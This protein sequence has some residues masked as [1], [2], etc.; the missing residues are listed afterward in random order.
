MAMIGTTEAA[1]RL[2]VSPRRDAA[3]ISQGILK[4]AK[5][6]KTW[7]VDEAEV[8]RVAKLKRP[9]GRPRKRLQ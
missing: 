9:P 7:V 2:K 1:R 4:A 8:S 6:G 3:M 5:V